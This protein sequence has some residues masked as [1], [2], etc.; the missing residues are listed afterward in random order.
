[1]RCECKHESVPPPLIFVF[2]FLVTQWDGYYR[3]SSQILH[4]KAQ[5]VSFELWNKIRVEPKLLAHPVNCKATF[6][7]S[8]K[9]NFSSDDVRRK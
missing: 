7:G 8:K 1:M 2:N 4:Y 6:S 9:P 5:K 3:V